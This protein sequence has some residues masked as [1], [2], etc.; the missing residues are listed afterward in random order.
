MKLLFDQNLPYCLVV[1]V[2]QGF[3]ESTHV[4]SIGLERSDDE[5]IWQYAREHVYCIVS[6][7]MDFYQRSIF[8]GQ[9][10][11]VI[12]I[13]AGNCNTTTIEK[14]LRMHQAVITHFGR[15]KEPSCLLLPMESL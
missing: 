9:P 12:W 8:F 11:K 3:P 15:D 4:R 13:R 10:P 1:A 2:Q 5:V 6:K 14:L 7:D